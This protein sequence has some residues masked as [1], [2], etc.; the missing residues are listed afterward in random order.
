M[1]KVNNKDT[2]TTPFFIPWTFFIPCAN[3]FIVNFEEVNAGWGLSQISF[4]ETAQFGR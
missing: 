3:V 1:F 4:S 2:R